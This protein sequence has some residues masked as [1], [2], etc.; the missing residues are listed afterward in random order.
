M[1]ELLLFAG[2]VA[3]SLLTW[4]VVCFR[5]VW[6][7]MKS[8]TLSDAAR[9]ILLLHCFRFIGL[10]FVVPG[11]VSPSL[12]ASFAVPAAY[13]DLVA[14]LLAWAALLALRGPFERLALWVFN[15][16]GTA[17]LLFAFY[18][19]VIG[20][21][22]APSA[23]GAAFFLPTICVPLLLVTHAMLFALLLSKVPRPVIA[24]A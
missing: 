20:V 17:D 5:H 11:V 6:P 9:P 24:S 8:A 1:N 7:S 3:L 22:I 15:L 10:A 18:Q 2:S 14:V 16:W 23:L 21:H 12:Q 13:G 19:G 4:S